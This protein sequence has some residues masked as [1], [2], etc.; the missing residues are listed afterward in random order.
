VN[1]PPRATAF[2]SLLNA[3]TEPKK[4][5]QPTNINFGLFPIDGIE[6]KGRKN[7]ELKREIQL[8]KAKEAMD[9]WLS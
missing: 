3:I 5:F 8:S 1:I 6:T 7:R 9:A 2:G 4:D